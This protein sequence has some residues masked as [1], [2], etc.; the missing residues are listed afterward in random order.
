MALRFH[1]LD[2]FTDSRFGGNPL[3]VVLEADGLDAKQMQLIAREFN[4]SET[5]F[6]LKPENPAHNARIRI[7]TPVLEIPFAGHP[8]VGTAALLAELLPEASGGERDALIVL[9]ETIGPVRIGVRLRQGEPA[10]AEFD[11]PRL[12]EEQGAV[13]NAERL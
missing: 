2:V 5:V 12:P 13:A 8:T 6:V 10:F 7:F 1:T 9:E 4:V 11:A 3:A